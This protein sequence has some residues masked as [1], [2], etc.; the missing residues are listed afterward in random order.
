M[1][2]KKSTY[3]VQLF[4]PFSF[5]EPES[6]IA[7]FNTMQCVNSCFLPEKFGNYEPIK[8]IF[9]IEKGDELLNK[10]WGN[11]FLWKAK[12]KGVDGSIIQGHDDNK[13]TAIFM[14][15]KASKLDELQ[16]VALVDKL[17]SQFDCHLALIHK[18]TQSEKDLNFG[19]LNKIAR[20]LFTHNLIDFGLPDLCWYTILGEPF[21]DSFNENLNDTNQGL[22]PKISF[23]DNKLVVKV[24][25]S[26]EEM[27][28]D[29]EGFCEK[30][31]LAKNLINDAL[32]WEDGSKRALTRIE[33]D[34]FKTGLK[35]I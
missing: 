4:S 24:T 19:N 30:R 5:E 27:E 6:G 20:G 13:H 31:A 18:F 7:F 26:I 22:Y 17:A 28:T 32:F 33:R 2:K 10:Y 16:L 15:L 25:E 35:F 9:S 29:F 3:F 34:T 23:K 1:K 14:R 11:P 8:N 21:I 12:L